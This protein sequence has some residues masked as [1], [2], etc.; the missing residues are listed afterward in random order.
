MLTWR[1]PAAVGAV[2]SL[3]LATVLLSETPT[4]KKTVSE[5]LRPAADAALAM[6]ALTVEEAHVIRDKG[7]ERPFTGRYWNT[8]EQG[9]YV[10]RQCGAPLYRSDAKFRSECGWPSFDAELPGAVRHAPD[11]DGQ[12]TEILCAACGGHLG[13]VF[14]GERLTPKNVRHCV[15]SLSIVLHPTAEAT[16]AGGCFWGVEHLLRQTPGVLSAT[17]G[18]AGGTVAKPTYEQVCSGRTGHAE[19]VRVVFDRERVSYE[20]LARLFFELHDPTTRDAQ[21]PDVGSQ[22]RSVVFY[23]DEAQQ[24]TALKLIGVLRARGYEVVTQVV[25]AAEFYPAEAY[26]QDYLTKHPERPSCHV[27]VA[28]FGEPPPEPAGVGGS[29]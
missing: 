17:S 26:H 10:C 23:H 14:T 18:Y 1:M 20:Q 12:R 25:P 19:A 22:Y 8:F 21:G 29:K 11:A 2:L 27:R 28:R 13:H 24:Q 9:V 3:L 15:N 5:P 4:E 16:F 6:P 7:T